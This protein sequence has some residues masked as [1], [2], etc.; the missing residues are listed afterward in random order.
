[1]NV[2]INS[3]ENECNSLLQIYPHFIHKFTVVARKLCENYRKC[4]K[5]FSTN[6]WYARQDLNTRPPGPKPGAL[7]AELRAHAFTLTGFE[8]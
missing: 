6:K 3:V 2:S 7:S 8:L 1:M 5:S 4:I